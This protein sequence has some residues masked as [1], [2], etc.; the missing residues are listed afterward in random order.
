M[1]VLPQVILTK[2]DPDNKEH[3][4][5]INLL[6]TKGVQHPSLRFDVERPF[7]NILDMAKH[8]MAAKYAAILLGDVYVDIRTIDPLAA[9]E[10]DILKEIGFITNPIRQA[11]TERKLSVVRSS[12]G[13]PRVSIHTS[14]LLE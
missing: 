8:I 7:T 9:T 11:K 4:K 12:N 5:A 2:F 10:A 6:L 1:S 13:A 3:I 14:P